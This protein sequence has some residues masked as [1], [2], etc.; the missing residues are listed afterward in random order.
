[1]PSARFYSRCPA[2]QSQTSLN[3]HSN[4]SLGI[5][6]LPLPRVVRSQRLQFEP[7][8]SALRCPWPRASGHGSTNTDNRQ[9][10]VKEPAFCASLLDNNKM[11]HD[12][13]DEHQRSGNIRS[14][15]PKV[16]KIIGLWYRLGSVP[17]PSAGSGLSRAVSCPQTH[18]NG[19]LSLMEA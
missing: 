8:H 1:M 10:T 15:S 3:D 5:P 12:E 18:R 2:L 7:C 16:S 11:L 13:A 4:E 9:R 6:P 19:R 14:H 17:D